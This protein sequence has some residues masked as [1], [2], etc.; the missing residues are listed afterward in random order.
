MDC[1]VRWGLQSVAG[2]QSELVHRGASLRKLQK[3]LL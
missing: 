3:A 2:L 1:K